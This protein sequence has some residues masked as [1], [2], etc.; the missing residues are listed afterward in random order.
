METAQQEVHL[1]PEIFSPDN[2]GVDD[3]LNINYCFDTPSLMGEVI[4]F[5]SAGRII[6]RLVNRQLLATEGTITWDGTDDRGRK[7]ITGVYIIYFQAYHS[8]GIQKVYKIPCV[9]ATKRN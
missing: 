3:I 2:D 8:N 4:V 6:R 1:S 7:A 5:D 9:L